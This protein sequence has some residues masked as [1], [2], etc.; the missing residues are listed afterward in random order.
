M[1]GPN[2]DLVRF[3]DLVAQGLNA[4]AIADRLGVTR[5]AVYLFDE[6][7][8]TGL[9]KEA[10]VPRCK[11]APIKAEKAPRANRKIDPDRLARWV[12]QGRSTAQI[13]Q[14]FGV[15]NP[16]V[17]TACHKY[18]LPL[19][20]S[21]RAL[22]GARNLVPADPEPAP[23]A[24]INESERCE[25]EL[26]ASGGTHAALAAWAAKWGDS[27]ANA[28]ARWARLKLPLAVQRRR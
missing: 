1:S 24:P 19:P 8:R 25:A 10:R 23:A 9:K 2:I 14:Q 15:R 4:P 20:G 5:A 17:I 6:K 13:A 26:I 18:E 28:R 12:W 22:A 7:H 11:P 21:P 27:H 3:R 16:A